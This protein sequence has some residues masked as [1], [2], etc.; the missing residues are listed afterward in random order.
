[1][2]CKNINSY[3]VFLNQTIF[4][5]SSRRAKLLKKKASKTFSRTRATAAQ[6]Y[7]E[8]TIACAPLKTRN[9]YFVLVANLIFGKSFSLK[10][11]D[12]IAC[13]PLKT[14]N[15]YFAL[16]AYLIFGK[17]FSL[18]IE[19]RLLN[20]CAVMLMHKLYVL[21]KTWKKLKFF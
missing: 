14:Q 3:N 1:L 16:V 15:I 5:K 12:R 7:R 8:R 17:S 9:I 18:K 21:T 6:T 4:Q 19:D 13:A 10:I 11:E 20:L 2:N